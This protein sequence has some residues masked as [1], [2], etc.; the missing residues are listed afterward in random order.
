MTA[1]LPI[2]A[3]LL[4]FAGGVSAQD[5][6][7]TCH[8]ASTYDLTV[9]PEA[10]VFDRAE[11]APRTVRMH[12][13]TL[14]TDGRRVALRPD[15]QD[16]VTLFERQVRALVPKAKAIA[17]DGVDLA[18]R[19]VRDEA[20]TAAPAALASGELDQVLKSR[21]A[22]IKRRIAASQST[23]DWQ[24]DAMRAYAQEI[25]ADVGP[26]L[27]NEVGGEAMQLAMNGDLQGAAALRDRVATVST[28]GQARVVARL[29]ASLRPRIQALCPSIHQLVDF[30]SGLRDASGKPLVLV[31]Q[32]E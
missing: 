15:E 27:T 3:A 31:E 20:S 22:D 14:E 1:R 29:E 7:T 13:G 25:V 12:D 30:Q 28:G 17:T 10:L 23:R 18:A 2:A 21:V 19:A 8:I 24:E 16:R 11:P 6:A 4:C 26:I 9:R 32:G 5:P